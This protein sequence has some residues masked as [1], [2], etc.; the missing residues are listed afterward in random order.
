MLKKRY[1]K[2][3]VSDSI[4]GRS[5]SKGYERKKKRERDVKI[6]EVALAVVGI[7][8]AWYLLKGRN[9]GKTDNILSI[10]EHFSGSQVILN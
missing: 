7:F 1:S 2:K 9:L 3:E 4:L 8:I 5:L 10:P 6:G